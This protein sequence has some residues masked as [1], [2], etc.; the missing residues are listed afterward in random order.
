[1]TLK[2]LTTIWF[3]VLDV[4]PFSKVLNHTVILCN[5]KREYTLLITNYVFASLKIRSTKKGVLKNWEINSGWLQ[6]KKLLCEITLYELKVY[7]I[8]THVKHIKTFF[9]GV[10]AAHLANTLKLAVCTS[11]S[12]KR[13]L[14]LS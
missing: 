14:P 1:M 7:K 13:R 10:T 2:R 4:V 6:L 8:V 5:R 11:F 12:E 3:T 9:N